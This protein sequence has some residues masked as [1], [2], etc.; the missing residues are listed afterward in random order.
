M[1]RL[2]ALMIVGLV[3]IGSESIA[4]TTESQIARQ[5][6]LREAVDLALQHNH[7][8]RLARLD[9]EEH[10]HV[11]EAARSAYFPSV[12]NDTP[13]TTVTDTPLI[14]IPA[15]GFGT[16]G[17]TLVPQ[18]SILLNQGG[19]TFTSSGFGLVQPLTQL[20]KINAANDVARA[21]VNG[22]RGKARNTENEIALK[23][24]KL[25]Y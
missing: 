20:F 4:Q 9:V 3:L 8:V 2:L 12:R 11:R 7:V 24:H 14:E 19:Q 22:A 25:Y 1:T 13:A 6:T 23:V 16:V 18:Q 5:I 10:E 17:S 15:G 21:L